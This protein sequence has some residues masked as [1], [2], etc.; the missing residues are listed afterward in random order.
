MLQLG[1]FHTTS[2]VIFGNGVVGF[3]GW[4]LGYI[5]S[6]VSMVIALSLARRSESL[7]LK[8]EGR[9]SP[10]WAAYEFQP[11]LP[12]Q[13][14]KSAEPQTSGGALVGAAAQS[15]LRR[16]LACFQP[17]S[18]HASERQG[19]LGRGRGCVWSLASEVRRRQS[20][21]SLQCF[22]ASVSYQ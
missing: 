4:F 13:D 7:V 21:P 5:V 16:S 22:W 3:E 15:Y 1:G 2:T 18:L 8:R 11:E 20:K 19:C 9:G 12:G 6:G 10:T 17:I 14:L